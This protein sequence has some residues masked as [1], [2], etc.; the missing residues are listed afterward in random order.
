MANQRIEPMTRSAVTLL[1][2][3]AASGALLVMA[4]PYRSA[5]LQKPNSSKL[6]R[7]QKY[8]ILGIVIASVLCGCA[9]RSLSK[10]TQVGHWY[11]SQGLSPDDLGIDKVSFSASP[12][13]G[14]VMTFRFTKFVDD[15]QVETDEMISH[16]SGR[17]NTESVVR[18]VPGRFPYATREIRAQP[19]TIKYG[20]AG[21]GF[22]C[23]GL[24]PVRDG[25]WGTHLE[26]VF[27]DSAMR[28]IVFAFDVT[29]EPL[30]SAIR[31]V[32]GLATAATGRVWGYHT[33]VT[34]VR[35]E[36]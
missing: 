14:Q 2:Q 16:T 9:S 4:H 36:P 11:A 3:S 12:S 26:F 29:I 7:S 10:N 8:I 5:E 24:T 17:L 18:W 27:T 33:G 28:S 31:R 25:F 30:S 32:P 21:G 1:V 20:S 6:M 34:P 22:S 15:K 23:E 19:I 13:A 35:A